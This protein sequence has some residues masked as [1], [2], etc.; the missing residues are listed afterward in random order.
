MTKMQSPQGQLLQLFDEKKCY[1]IQE[2]SQFLNYSL[3]SI[4]R[5]LKELGYYSSFTHN[6]KWY[7]LHSIPFFNKEGIW[8]SK[9]IGFSKHGNLNQTILY[10]VNASEQG[11]TAKELLS[12]L[13]VP[14]HPVLNLMYKKKQI[15][16]SHTP[17]GFVYLSPSE[18]IKMLQM[19]RLQSRSVFPAKQIQRLTAQASVYVLVEFIKHPSASFSQLSMAVRKRHILASEEAI[20]QLFKEHGI[21]K[22]P[23]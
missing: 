23:K 11:L 6:S 16:R 8:F 2:L 15:D 18:D 20:A 22:T 17:R 21:K 10:F 14:C 19:D 3:I 7:T 1:T 9:D 5:F 12:I 13:L 4:R